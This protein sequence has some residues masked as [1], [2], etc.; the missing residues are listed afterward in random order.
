MASHRI[1]FAA[2]VCLALGLVNAAFAEDVEPGVIAPPIATPELSSNRVELDF[3]SGW[4][5]HDGTVNGPM[6]VYSADVRVADA[7]W[8]RLVFDTVDLAGHVEKPDHSYILVTSLLDGLWQKLD[9]RSIN[10]WSLTSAYFNGQE[11]RVELIAFPGT[12]L[13]RMSLSGV[14]AGEPTGAGRSICGTVDDR[15]LS[16]DPRAGRYLPSGC[17]AW[18]IDMGDN[19][20]LSA[21][22][23]GISGGGVVQFNVPLSNNNGS[24]NH[25]PPE[26]QYPVDASSVQVTPGVQLGNDWAF[27]GCFDN[28]NTGLSPRVAQG[29]A[30]MLADSAPAV[31]GQQIRITGYGTV[32]SPVSPTWNQ[33]EKTHVGPYV[34]NNGAVLR[35]ATD[36]SGGNSGS[37]V[38]L[39]GGMAIGIHT[40][41]GC[42]SV[43][44]NQGTSIDS[45]TLQNALANPQGVCDNLPPVPLTPPI[46]LCASD[47]LRFGSVDPDTGAFTRGVFT[48]ERM[49][50]LAWNTN[51]NIFYA[52]SNGN[53]DFFTISEDGQ[54]LVAI[55]RITGLVGRIYGLAYDPNTDTLFGINQ[56]DGQLYELNTTTAQATPIG[57]AQGGR[58]GSLAFDA[59]TNTLYGAR[60]PLFGQSTLVTI[61]VATGE[62]AIIGPI[63]PGVGGIDG[64]GF[65]PGDGMLYTLNDSTGQLLRVDPANGLASVVGSVGTPL[66][67]TYGMACTEEP[68][69]ADLNNDGILDVLDFFL[70]ISLFD[71][72]DPAV[73]FNNDSIIDV[74]DFFL[75]VS[76]FD[77][78]C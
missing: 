63:G 73:D 37:A 58:V 67:S 59:A 55:G 39:D 8:L 44:G 5:E 72:N 48:G 45:P 61:N 4:V 54:T 40:N 56:T 47:A 1:V 35:Y 7:G 15:V 18:L 75:F 68:C 70:F 41:A 29:A 65:R 52:T 49:Q 43:G 17:T 77:A 74:L 33:V 23:C 2:G 27:F 30:Y 57:T 9:Q 31:N 64:L 22:H 66:S 36:T 53:P 11:V 24:L 62:Q 21:G 13:S 16:S 78:G 38:E 50:G 19:C 14:D 46:Y 12:G 6:V 71:Q 60:N 25:P 26:D 3:D 69:P 20:F 34:M 76:L 10:Q 51:D 28:S 42:N 32:S